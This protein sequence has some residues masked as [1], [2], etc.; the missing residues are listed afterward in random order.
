MLLLLLLL[1]FQIE[2]ILQTF[3]NHIR[4]ALFSRP[5]TVRHNKLLF[6]VSSVIYRREFTLNYMLVLIRV[7]KNVAKWIEFNWIA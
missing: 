3:T 1:L 2:E 4:K 5:C 7:S 6:E